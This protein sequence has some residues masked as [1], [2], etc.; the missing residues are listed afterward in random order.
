[1]VIKVIA[2]K[3]ATNQDANTYHPNSVENQCVSIDITQSQAAIEE[4]TAKKI[5]KNAD[6][7]LIL[8]Q[9]EVPPIISSL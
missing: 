2:D 1:M 3:P 5:K 9:E 6:Q 7:L 8:Y 4:D